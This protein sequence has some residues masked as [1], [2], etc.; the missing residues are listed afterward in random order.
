MIRRIV[1]AYTAWQERSHARAM[2][3]HAGPRGAYA[4]T[5]RFCGEWAITGDDAAQI[6]FE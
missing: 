6:G 2:H 3:F 5:N 1:T 4:C